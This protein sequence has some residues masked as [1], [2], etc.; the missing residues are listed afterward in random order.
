ML[1]ALVQVVSNGASA[2]AAELAFCEGS[3]KPCRSAMRREWVRMGGVANRGRFIPDLEEEGRVRREVGLLAEHYGEG[4]SFEEWLWQTTT[5]A[6]DTEVNVQTGEFTV[7]RNQVSFGRRDR[8]RKS[9]GE[10]RRG[11][12]GGEGWVGGE[13]EGSWE[14]EKVDRRG[15]F[16]L[17]VLYS[18]LVGTC[19]GLIQ[20]T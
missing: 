20:A 2:S 16:S 10:G 18:K 15:R 11:S 14:E 12:S 17:A 6:A 7:R 9:V 8:G 1:D 4:G 5:A 3:S 19:D 13:R